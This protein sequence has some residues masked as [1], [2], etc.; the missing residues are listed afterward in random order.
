MTVR[1]TINPD[2]GTR[3]FELDFVVVPRAGEMIDFGLQHENERQQRRVTRVLHTLGAPE[4]SITVD[5][6]SKIL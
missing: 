1:C 2:D 3:P 6:T 5:V 4:P